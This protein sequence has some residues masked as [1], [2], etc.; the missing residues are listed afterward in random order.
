M[1][2]PRKT[3]ACIFAC[4]LHIVG[5]MKRVRL[6]KVWIVPAISLLWSAMAPGVSAGDTLS[7]NDVIQMAVA[8]AQHRS[9]AAG[10]P[11]YLYTKVTVTEEMDATGAVKERQEKVYEVQFQAGST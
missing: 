6:G 8:R 1:R 4:S 5:S 7:A 2:P 11:S 9:A 10:Q 3:P